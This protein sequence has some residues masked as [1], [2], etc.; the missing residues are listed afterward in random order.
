MHRCQHR[1][2]AG[3]VS[4]TVL[5]GCATSHKEAEDKGHVYEAK[6]GY[7][8]TSVKVNPYVPKPFHVKSRGLS[9]PP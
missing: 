1:M 8:P 5:T 6:D 3:L 2:I 9:A 4:V 7:K